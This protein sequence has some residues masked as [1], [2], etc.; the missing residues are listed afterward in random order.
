MKLFSKAINKKLFAQFPK[1]N[2]LEEQVVVTCIF[3]PYGKPGTGRWYI[4]NSNP[5]DPDYLWCIHKDED[6]KVN[7]GSISRMLLETMRVPPFRFPLER[8]L[9]FNEINA[10]ALLKSLMENKDKYEDGG[11]LGDNNPEPI[12]AEML[13][14]RITLAKKL[15]S[16]HPD[17]VY[18]VIK[19]QNDLLLITEKTDYDAYPQEEK[20]LLE[21]MFD[22]S[23][24]E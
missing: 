4:V 16:D 9:W 8:D 6:G 22:S 11:E 15:A 2:N 5:D 19:D 23:V 13:E 21:I 24:I 18:L 7:T 10:A 20:D 14:S 12:S 17:Q 3:N 1:G